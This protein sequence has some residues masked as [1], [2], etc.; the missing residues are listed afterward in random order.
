MSEKEIMKHI[1]GEWY[2]YHAMENENT[3]IPVIIISF[4]TLFL[5]D[6]IIISLGIWIWYAMYCSKNNNA[7]NNNPRVLKEREAWMKIHREK[8]EEEKYKRILGI[9]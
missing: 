8:G 3:L 9:N 4:L 6:G 1:T 2:L 5:Y 7:L